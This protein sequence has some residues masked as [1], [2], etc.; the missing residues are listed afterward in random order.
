MTGT[1]LHTD[2][3]HGYLQEL[4]S[5][6]NST[7]LNVIALDKLLTT[8]V[9]SVLTSREEIRVR[10]TDVKSDGSDTILCETSEALQR[11]LASDDEGSRIM[12]ILPLHLASNIVYR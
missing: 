9:P 3:W 8:R 2:M 6:H 10:V 12:Y 5:H 7:F 4:P 1:G 11:A